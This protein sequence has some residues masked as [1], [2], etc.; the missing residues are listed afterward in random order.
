MSINFILFFL[1]LNSLN[2][3]SAENLVTM[4]VGGIVSFG[5]TNWIKNQTGAMGFGAMC[6]A[7]LVSVAVAIAAVIISL[8]LSGDGFS[9]EKATASA[10]Q[11][12]AVATVAYKAMMADKH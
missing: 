3:F 8:F 7:L 9:W 10:V 6:L 11:V 1:S 12:F 4:L 2:F 5:L